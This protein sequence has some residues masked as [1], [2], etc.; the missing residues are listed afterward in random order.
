MNYPNYQ[1][2]IDA[3]LYCASVCNYC[4]SSCI[5][6]EDV[7][8]MALCIQLDMECAAMCYAAAQLMSLGSSDAKAVCRLCANFCRRCA[9]ECDRHD[10]E[11]CRKCADACRACAIAC[12][13]M[14]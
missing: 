4:A 5:K 7:K 6:E 11:H 9:A 12:E 10:N 13:N 2:C 3:C 1:R 14:Q 8:M